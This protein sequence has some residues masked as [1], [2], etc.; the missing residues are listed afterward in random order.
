MLV[1]TFPMNKVQVEKLAI[2]A[3]YTCNLLQNYL[4][5]AKIW[6]FFAELYENFID[7]FVLKVSTLS[8]FQNR[9]CIAS[10]EKKKLIYS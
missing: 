8:R 4:K 10:Q 9:I 6:I 7:C 5:G 1:S 2:M 3:S